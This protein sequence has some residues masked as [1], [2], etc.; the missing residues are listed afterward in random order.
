MALSGAQGDR[1]DAAPGRALAHA[2][3]ALRLVRQELAA[4]PQPP[5][6]AAY[7]SSVSVRRRNLSPSHAKASGHWH[8]SQ[9]PHAP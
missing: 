4:R 6:R 7:S 3:G 8:R 9:S 1:P 5:R 2:C